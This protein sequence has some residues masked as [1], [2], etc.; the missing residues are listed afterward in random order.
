MDALLDH[1]ASARSRDS[2]WSSLRYSLG[3][4]DT[5][6]YRDRLYTE[7]GAGV[8]EGDRTVLT[9]VV[10]GFLLT[11]AVPFIP[12]DRTDEVIPAFMMI[13]SSSQR[14]NPL[15]FGTAV[16]VALAF[17]WLTRQELLC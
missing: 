3:R 12:W 1:S 16:F 13:R 4:T 7:R 10:V 8:A 5:R 2:Y 14:A 9:S 11:T 15:L 17:V 6:R